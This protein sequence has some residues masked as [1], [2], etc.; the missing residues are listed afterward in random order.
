MIS[1]ERSGRWLRWIALLAGGLS[2]RLDRR[3]S[4]IRMDRLTRADLYTAQAAYHGVVRSD[5]SIRF[6]SSAVDGEGFRGRSYVPVYCD[7][8]PAD[9]LGSGDRFQLSFV[10]SWW[11]VMYLY[12]FLLGGAGVAA[13]G[14]GAS[15]SGGRAVLLGLG[16][17]MVA[18]GVLSVVTRRRQFTT[19]SWQMQA[20][21][22]RVI[23]Q[24]LVADGRGDGHVFPPQVPGRRS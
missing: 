1:T 14:V 10:E 3:E 24:V 8:R 19:M 23:A 9:G 12:L 18:V 20:N 7:L 21:L 4:E 2:L 6:A 17:V 11:T 15:S 5:G 13:A 16:V 22:E